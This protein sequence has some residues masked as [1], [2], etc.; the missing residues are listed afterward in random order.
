M[1][2]GV[3]ALVSSG[4]AEQS[5]VL[6]LLS[7]ASTTLY[8]QF[9]P[10]RDENLLGLVASYTIFFAAFTSLLVKLRS[11]FLTSP[12]VDDL[13]CFAVMSPLI[14]AFIL[15]EGLVRS[16]GKI[17]A[18]AP[19]NDRLHTVRRYFSSSFATT[20]RNV[21]EDPEQETNRTPKNGSMRLKSSFGPD[22][23]NPG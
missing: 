15:S 1:L 20:A 16:M 3:V 2:A 4:T 22:G 11:D 5:I 19:G 17:C 12:L 13:L 10:L 7:L 14:V 6:M 21:L 8:H 23:P 18:T 9:L